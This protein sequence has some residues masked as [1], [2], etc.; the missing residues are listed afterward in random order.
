MAG[1]PDHNTAEL[2]LTSDGDISAF[3]FVEA[4]VASAPKMPDWKFTAL[5]PPMPIDEIIIQMSGYEVSQEKLSFFSP[6]DP[7]YPDLIDLWIVYS[8]YNKEDEKNIYSAVGLFLENYLGE[9]DFAVKVDHLCVIGPADTTE[10]RIGI[11]KLKEYLHW[12]EQEFVEKYEGVRHN[13]DQ[14]CYGSFEGSQDG[15]PMIASM[16]T[17]LLKWDAK[18]SHPW[19]LGIDLNYSDG[20]EG[21]PGNKSYG[22]INAF[23]REAEASLKPVDGFLNIGR[24][25]GN[26]NCRIT[27]ACKD[28][29]KAAVLIQ[30]LQ[31]KYKGSFDAIDYELFKDKYWQC[32]EHFNA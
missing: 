13:V 23:E 15:R 6:T 19:I 20:K 12:R 24:Q 29:R 8:D 21:L 18:A 3:V 11:A 1:M 31:K 27:F 2:V 32:L 26:N 28:F 5:K 22:S 17:T 30:G 7:N 4:L 9:L 25:M 14:D 16:N 10:E